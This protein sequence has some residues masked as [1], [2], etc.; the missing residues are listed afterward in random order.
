[1][2]C[3]G[4]AVGGQ[5]TLFCWVSSFLTNHGDPLIAVFT[6]NLLTTSILFLGEHVGGILGKICFFSKISTKYAFFVNGKTH[7]FLDI[8]DL[9]NK[10]CSNN[11]LAL[12]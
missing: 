7:H 2:H 12:P 9:K 1:M 10:Y 3:E 6:T 8:M 5:E 11:S 4:W